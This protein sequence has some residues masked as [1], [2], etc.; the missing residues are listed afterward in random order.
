MLINHSD[1][2]KRKKGRPY[3]IAIDKKGNIVVAGGSRNITIFDSKGNLIREFGKEFEK[4]G[5]GKG[6]FNF[7]QDV[8]FDQ[9]GNLLVVEFDLISVFSYSC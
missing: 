4:K 7:P 6:E 3:G 1:Y 5:E 8:C 9:N 2:W